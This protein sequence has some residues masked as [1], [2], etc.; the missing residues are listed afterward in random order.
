[1]RYRLTCGSQQ[2]RAVADGGNR[3]ARL[4]KVLHHLNDLRAGRFMCGLD[5]MC[6]CHEASCWPCWAS[7]RNALSR[8]AA[9]IALGCLLVAAFGADGCAYHTVPLLAR[10]PH[11][12]MQAIHWAAHLA[13]QP[14]IL[15]CAAPAGKAHTGGSK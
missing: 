11:A 12:A 2:L 14:Q 1:M 3:L 6:V 4:H 5:V 13:V 7:Q 10:K 15:G 8:W 9:S